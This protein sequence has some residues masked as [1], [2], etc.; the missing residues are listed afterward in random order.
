MLTMNTLTRALATAVVIAG[1]ITLA[2]CSSQ[3]G[4]VAGTAAPTSAPVKTSPTPTPTPTPEAAVG[5]RAKPFPVGAPGRYDSTSVW[6]M[7][8][9]ATDADAWP[10][11][12]KVN[13]YN[14]APKEGY[15]DVLGTMTVAAGAVDDAGADPGQSLSVTYVGSDANSYDSIN[16]P[17]GVLADTELQDAGTMY[18]GASRSV[19]VCAQVPTTAIAGGSWAVGFV[20]GSTAPAFFASA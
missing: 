2:G 10:E 9:T 11:V 13:M 15:S 19:L 8:F 17:C 1:A 7:T 6:T 12:Q 14:E 20:D 5:T 16:H 4:P 3:S 18:A